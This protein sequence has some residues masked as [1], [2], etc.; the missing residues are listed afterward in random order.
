MSLAKRYVVLKEQ[1]EYIG[2]RQLGNHRV[3][4][5]VVCGFYVEMW[6]IF[7]INQIHWIE[8]QENQSIISEYSDN[9]DIKKDLGL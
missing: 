1:S 2:V 8:I 4:L 9:I 6:I 5:Y 3:H 7:A